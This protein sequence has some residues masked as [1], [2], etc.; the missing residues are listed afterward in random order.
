MLTKPTQLPQQTEW[1]GWDLDGLKLNLHGTVLPNVVWNKLEWFGLVWNMIH[2]KHMTD[3][4]IASGH[5]GV[6]ASWR[7][8][9]M[10]LW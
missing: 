6:K 2:C 3:N 10:A 7:H 5:H 9:F 1:N 4:I 8:G